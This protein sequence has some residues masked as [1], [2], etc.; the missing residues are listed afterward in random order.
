MDLRQLGQRVKSMR[1]K[2]GLRQ[3]DIA[4]VLQVSAQAVSKW[5]RGENAP[6]IALLVQLSRIL[7]VSV[8]WILEGSHPETDTFEAT[9]FLADLKNYAA[10][11]TGMEPRALAEWINGVHYLVTESVRRYDGVPVKYMGDATLA[12]FAGRRQADRAVRAARNARSTLGLKDLA[13]TIHRGQI[14]LGSIG[15]PD[16]ARPDILGETVN[17][18]WLVSTQVAGCCRTGVGLTAATAEALGEE[19]T[20]RIRQAGEVDVRGLGAPVTVYEV[21]IDT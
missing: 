18:T 20:G 12:F 16:Y 4:S 15:H 2:N 6:D 19:E 5:E 1:E 13:I 11:A 3:A 7:G 14:Y 17:T 21:A 8:E 9:V 10:K